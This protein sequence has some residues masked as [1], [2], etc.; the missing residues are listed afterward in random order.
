MHIVGPTHFYYIGTKQS[1]LIKQD[2]LSSVR[3]S[4]LL[5]AIYLEGAIIES[6]YSQRTIRRE[7]TGTRTR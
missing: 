7:R 2:V 5:I 6:C 4:T 3:G 1:V